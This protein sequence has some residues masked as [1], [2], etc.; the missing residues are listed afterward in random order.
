MK[1]DGDLSKEQRLTSK[2]LKRRG[3]DIGVS[4]DQDRGF[5][6]FFWRNR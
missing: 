5:L 3:L 2:L 1:V 4:K 6:W